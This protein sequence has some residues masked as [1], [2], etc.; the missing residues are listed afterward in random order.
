MLIC[1]PV[2]MN[3][4]APPPESDHQVQFATS[5]STDEPHF[6]IYNLRIYLIKFCG[7][8]EIIHLNGLAPYRELV[9]PQ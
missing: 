7:L 8:N 5:E 3:A 2:R 9:N 6:L 4:K 1:C